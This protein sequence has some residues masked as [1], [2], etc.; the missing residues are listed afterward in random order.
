MSRRFQMRQKILAL[1]HDFWVKDEQD[2]EVFFVDNRLLALRKTYY[3]LDDDKHE[4]LKVQ[5]KLMHIHRT[6]DIEQHGH[7]IAS[8]QKNLI[9]PLL[10][11]WTIKVPDGQDLNAQGD[12]FDHE[13]SINGPG[14]KLAHI[15]KK[16][17]TIGQSYGIEVEDGVPVPLIIA[18]AIAIDDMMDSIHEEH[19]AQR[20][21]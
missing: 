13:Y 6:M 7:V 20:K 18:I 2:Q 16:W 8:V 17:F 15:S 9:S 14:G 11:R 3:I 12:L 19:E 5:H 10:D 21:S 1:G 4:L